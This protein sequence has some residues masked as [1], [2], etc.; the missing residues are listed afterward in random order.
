MSLG[1]EA[2][3]TLH[4][5]D[6]TWWSWS[7]FRRSNWVC[8]EWVLSVWSHWSAS[9]DLWAGGLLALSS[10]EDQ[11][12]RILYD[13][14]NMCAIRQHLLALE[15]TKLLVNN[16]YT[17]MKVQK[18][19]LPQP[20]PNLGETLPLPAQANLCQSSKRQSHL[21]VRIHKHAWK[22]SFYNQSRGAIP[23]PA[24]AYHLNHAKGRAT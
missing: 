1:D 8:G 13:E 7:R 3:I 24:P 15:D 12:S 22:F 14:E 17:Y 20:I 16:P 2:N 5:F 9:A 4:A 21:H 10:R 11:A 19:Y 23:L 6:L 18:V